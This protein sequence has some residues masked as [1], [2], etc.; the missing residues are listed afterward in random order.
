MGFPT[1][2]M[3]YQCSF[4]ADSD[5]PFQPISILKSKDS[6]WKLSSPFSIL[7]RLSIETSLLVS[8]VIFGSSLF[9]TVTETVISISYLAK[10]PYWQHEIVSEDEQSDF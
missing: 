5:T 8:I 4:C 1:F 3:G 6:E 7:K 9:V 2:N 10:F